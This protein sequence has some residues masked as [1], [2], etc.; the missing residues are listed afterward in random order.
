M[1]N[2]SNSLLA[3]AAEHGHTIRAGAVDGML[4]VTCRYRHPD[5]SFTFGGGH[6]SATKAAVRDFLAL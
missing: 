2:L 3:F 1:R 6:V 5:G 4:W